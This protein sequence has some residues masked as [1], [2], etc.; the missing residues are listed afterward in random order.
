MARPRI[1]DLKL[2]VKIAKKLGKKDTISINKMVSRKA[3]KLG[4]SAESALIL[5]AKEYGIGASTYQRNLGVTKQAEVRD[6]LPS[7]FIQARAMSHENKTKNNSEVK[8][9]IS[10]KTALKLTIE[11]LIEDQELRSRC[12]DILMASANFDRP[13]NQATLVLEDR[14]RKKAKPLTKM[15]GE[16]LVGYAFN[17][18]ISKTVL[19]VASNDADDQR[20]FAQILRGIV[21]AFR[22]KTHHHIVE[23]FSR[24]EAIRVCGFIDVLLRVVDNS[25]KIK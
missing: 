8:P 11:Y 7:I 18:E 25:V 16:N 9:S 5:L 10:K 17:E 1:L 12:Q 21:P 13:I 19:R 15:V 4:I 20:G 24:E 22:N 14:I 6:A 2:M 3:S 23:H